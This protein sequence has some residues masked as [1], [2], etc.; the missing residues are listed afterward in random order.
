VLGR[1]TQGVRIIRMGEGERV[2]AAARMLDDGDK[3]EEDASVVPRPEEVSTEYVGATE[4]EGDGA[5][6]PE[7]D[8]AEGDEPEASEE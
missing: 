2:V 1:N 7:G 8:G 4:V 5:D 3:G 6:E